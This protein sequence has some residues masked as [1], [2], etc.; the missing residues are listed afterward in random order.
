[1]KKFRDLLIGY[2]RALI[3]VIQSR[4][5]IKT[6]GERKPLKVALSVTNE[7]GFLL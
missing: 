1:M 4:E 3:S 2:E 5:N 7:L 6:L